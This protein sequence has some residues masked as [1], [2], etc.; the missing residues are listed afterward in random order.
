MEHP[1]ETVTAVPQGEIMD[2]L[3]AVTMI[4]GTPMTVDPQGTA[5]VP[6]TGT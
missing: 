3:P 2:P 1:Q 6:E 4:L 5:T